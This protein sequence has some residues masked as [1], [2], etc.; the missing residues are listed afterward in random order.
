MKECPKCSKVYREDT[1]YCPLD[2]SRLVRS[3]QVTMDVEPV[4]NER[5]IPPPSKPLPL[6]L[7][8]IDQ[9]DEGHR[10]RL[11]DG[12][13]LDMGRQG[14]RIQTGTIETGKLHI[15]RDHTVAFKNKLELEIDLPKGT[16]RCTG[17]AAWY[18]PEGGGLFWVVGVYIRDMSASDRKAY[19]EY[20]EEL[21]AGGG[22]TV[23]APA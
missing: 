14:M 13:V 2:G 12:L 17:F 11:I 22:E 4:K 3:V 6:R 21:A 9:S 7:T 1:Q 8:I 10:S 19:D 16:I 23:G 18:R 5:K 15:I 20:L